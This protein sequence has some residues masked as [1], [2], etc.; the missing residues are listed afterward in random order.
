MRLELR[1][2]DGP[3]VMRTRL[4][5]ISQIMDLAYH[6]LAKNRLRLTGRCTAQSCSVK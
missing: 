3:L 1:E 6:V 4:S 5:V 2:I